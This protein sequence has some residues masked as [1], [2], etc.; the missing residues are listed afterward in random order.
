MTKVTVEMLERVETL[1]PIYENAADWAGREFPALAPSEHHET[2][3]ALRA[4]TA[5]CRRVIEPGEAVVERCADAAG[6]IANIKSGHYL[7]DVAR[8]V[9]AAIA[10]PTAS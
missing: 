7:E 9:L 2:A 4:L 10:D 3:K 6:E 8:A 1:I 5:L